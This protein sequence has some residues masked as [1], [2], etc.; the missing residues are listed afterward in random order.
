MRTISKKLFSICLVFSLLLSLGPKTVLRGE[1]TESVDTSVVEEAEVGETNVSLEKATDLLLDDSSRTFDVWDFGGEQFSSFENHTYRNKLNVDL[2]NS[3]FDSESGTGGVNIKEDLIFLGDDGQEE[4]VFRTGGKSNHRLRTTN[5]AIT[6]YDE[7]DKKNAADSTMTYKGFVYSNAGKNPDARFEIDVKAGD[8]V[9]WA[10]GS[11]GG[12]S[13][14]VWESPSG[15]KDEKVFTSGSKA[16][17]MLFYAAEDGVYS[18]YS[19]NEKIVVARVLRERPAVKTIEGELVSPVDF[20]A[21]GASLIFTNTDSKAQIESEVSDNKFSANLSATYSYEINLEGANGYIVKSPEIFTV[22]ENNNAL[23]VEVVPVDL[24]NVKGSLKNIDSETLGRIELHLDSDGVYQPEVTLDRETAEFSARLEIGVEYRL[25]TVG[26]ED[27]TLAQDTIT[28]SED[29]TQDIVFVKKPT[30]PIAISIEGAPLS[31]TSDVQIVFSRV[32]PADGTVVEPYIYSFTGVENIELRDGQY[33]VEAMLNGYEQNLTPDLKVMGGGVSL[34]LSFTNNQVEPVSYRSTLEVGENKEFKTIN[35]ALDEVRKMVRSKSDSVT[36][37]ID[38]GNYEEMLVIDMENIHLKNSAVNPGT[39]LSNEGRDIG[40]N[41]V[42]ITSYYGHG[43]SYYSMDKDCKYSEALLAANKAN[44]YASYE[45]PGAGTTDG[46]Y[47]NATVVVTASNVSA[48]DIIFENSFN[49]YVSKKAAEDV[50]IPQSGARQGA[51]P[52]ADLEEGAVEVQDKAYVERAAALAI[53]NDL[54]SIKFDGCKFI[55]RQDTLYGGRNT[56]VTFKNSSVYGS[57]DFIFGPMI[58]IFDHCDLVLNTS[59]DKNDVA[60]ITAAQQ[61]E[62]R[63]YLMDT[64]H[65][66][67]A[68]PGLETASQYPSKPGYLGRPWKANSSEVVF[69]NTTIDAADSHWWDNSEIKEA[70]HSLIIS[71]GW[72]D[73]LGGE[74]AGMQEYGTTELAEDFVAERVGWAQ[75]LSEPTMTD[76]VAISQ[77]AFMPDFDTEA[78]QWNFAAFGSGIDTKNNGFEGDLETGLTLFSQKGKGKIVPASTDGLAFYYTKINPLTENFT[79]SADVEVLEWNYSNGQEGFGLMAADRIGEHGNS[80]SFWNNSYMNLISKVEYHW[81]KAEEKVSNI[82]DKYAMRLG[83]GS[84]EKTG[85]TLENLAKDTTAKAFKSTMLP[86]DTSLARNGM[87][88]ATY[89]LVGNCTNGTGFPDYN[90][91]TNFRLTLQRNNTG[92]FLSYTD[93]TGRETINKYYRDGEDQLTVLDASNIYVGFFASR[94]AKIKI[95]NVSLETIHPAKD[96]P[97]E[98]RPME[99][100]EPNYTIESASTANNSS[101]DLV[102]YGN[103]DGLLTI[104]DALTGLTLA[105]DLPVEAGNKVRQNLT[106]QEGQN[107]FKV[108]FMP[109]PDFKIDE[110]TVLSTYDSRTLT[111]T[112]YLVN[113][114]RDIVYIGPEGT[115]AGDGSRQNPVDI[116]TAVNSARPGQKLVLLE[117]HYLLDQT[118]RMERG[119]DGEANREIILMADPKASTRPVLDF[120]EKSAGLVLGSSYWV[121]QG[122]D[123]TRSAAGQKGVQVSGHYN[124]LDNLHTYRNGNT[125]IQISRL[126]GSDTREEWPSH[127]L[128]LNCTSYLNADPGYE[129]ADGFAAKLTIGE[130]NVFDGCIAAYNADDGWDLFAKVETGPIG[131]VVI[132]NSLAYKNGYDL[133]PDGEEIVAGNGNGF[134]MGGSSITGYHELHNSIAFA[135]KAKGIDSN[136]CPDIQVWNSTS[137]NNESYNVAFYTNDANKTD[138]AA[139]G[140]LSY[141]DSNLVAEQIRLKDG[142]DPAKVQGDSNYYLNYYDQTGQSKNQSGKIVTSDWFVNLDMNK[143]IHGGIGRDADGSIHMNGFLELS[144]KAAENT[145]ARIGQT[146]SPDFDL[147]QDLHWEETGEEVWTPG[148]GDYVVKANAN[149]EDLL[150]VRFGDSILYSKEAGSSYET[151][152]YKLEKGSTILMLKEDFLKKQKPAPYRLIMEFATGDTVEDGTLVLSIDIAAEPEESTGKPTSESSGSVKNPSEM[153]PSETHKSGDEAAVTGETSL[154]VIGFGTGLIL[155]AAAVLGVRRREK[156]KS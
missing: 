28:V 25:T 141:K 10:I 117:G 107:T 112:V 47:W 11:N 66:R 51:V 67:S 22:S 80:A 130:G 32:N 82:G 85:V 45:N 29:S 148:D 86:L 78:R 110:H 57:T 129:D 30:Y 111:H 92:Y 100:V 61:D 116:Y 15:V 40:A 104:E 8:R 95:S 44:G 102:F 96:A 71:E 7:K 54:H 41:A 69:Y 43:F 9:I 35:A 39:K 18:L 49:Q 135:N 143:A 90:P 120:Q 63:G 42:R 88:P 145:G 144:A 1:G 108:S 89:N 132:K 101:Y 94:N 97:A 56:Y 146:P 156:D 23:E 140:I 3:K 26:A 19:T 4:L 123:V 149:L 53:K 139:Q 152:D 99:T 73:T 36:I 16:E 121:L 79:L 65:I 70:S 76:G 115:K 60:Y 128:I 24:V 113:Q 106:L 118:V 119:M 91:Q 83:L 27:Y 72:T 14:I 68:I 84:Q 114:G 122:F 31:S 124:L 46:S 5:K 33:K 93:S 17:E 6:R 21:S 138:F 136:S 59:D 34:T 134:K 2:I 13:N 147:L 125:G 12:D 137:Y 133:G 87:A 98:E 150:L 105:K 131:K 74:S 38:P 48:T 126:M 62:G 77:E 75:V 58:A 52:R 103:A 55:G 142:Q 109:N 153:T 81:D 50:M 64:C 20:P 127:N 151:S 37:S 155:L 154:F